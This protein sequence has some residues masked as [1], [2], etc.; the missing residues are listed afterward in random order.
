MKK[1]R[2]EVILTVSDDIDAND[3]TVTSSDVIDGFEISRN[4]K[5]LTDDV[6]ENFYLKDCNIVAVREISG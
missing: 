3:I 1:I 2:L 4:L 5:S 6:T